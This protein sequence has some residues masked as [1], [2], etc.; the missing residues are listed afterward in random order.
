MALT[1]SGVAARAAPARCVE[2]D[3]RQ[4]AGDRVEQRPAR[5]KTPSVSLPKPATLHALST[6][7]LY[8]NFTVTFTVTLDGSSESS[9]SA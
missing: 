7:S 6:K 3:H 4:R 9:T 5:G 8:V 1:R 2:D